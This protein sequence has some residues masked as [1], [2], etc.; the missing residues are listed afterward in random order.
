[1]DSNVIDIDH[2]DGLT[3]QQPSSHMCFACGVENTA[4][5][6]MKFFNDGPNACRADFVLD[7][8]YQSFPGRMHGGIIAVILDE[9]MGRAALSGNLERMMVTAKMEIRYRQTTPLFQPLTVKARLE[10]DRGRLATASAEVQLADGTIVVEATAT[11]AAI[12]AEELAKI[13]PDYVGWRVYP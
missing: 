8:R 12:P 1:M 10:K 2:I 13:N 4:G 6:Q 5:L 3:A 7:D 11:L 9:A